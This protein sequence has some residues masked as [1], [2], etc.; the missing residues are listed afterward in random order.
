MNLNRN[1]PDISVVIF[2]CNSEQFV[3][4]AIE[5]ILTQ[6]LQPCEILICDDH[7]LDS[8]WDI[9]LSYAERHPALIR[10]VR[11]QRNLGQAA[12]GDFGKQNASGKWIAWIDGDDRWKPR[13]LE[14]EWLALQKNPQAKFASSNVQVINEQGRGIEEWKAGNGINTVSGNIFLQVFAKRFFQGNNRSI[15]R[16]YLVDKQ[17]LTEIGWNDPNLECFWDWD[18][19]IR[20]SYKYPAAFTGETLVE[21]RLHQTNFAAREHHKHLNAMICVYEKNLPLL[22]NRTP[23]EIA[24]IR[25]NVEMSIAEKQRKIAPQYHHPE[26]TW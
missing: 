6:T 14:L 16:N 7:S 5:S 8:T 1:R 15:F 2:T 3:R 17:A 13:K 4:E 19:K 24:Y 21:Y 26:Y 9:I 25:C 20:L 23:L 11:H 22:A 10:P 12:N 18:E